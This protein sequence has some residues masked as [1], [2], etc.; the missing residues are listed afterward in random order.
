MHRVISQVFA[1]C[2]VLAVVHRIHNTLDWDRVAVLDRGRLVE[3]D[4]PRK[5]LAREDSAFRR[6]YE[7]HKDDAEEALE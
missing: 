6:L 3:F 4:N 2:T 1:E 7:G 5:L